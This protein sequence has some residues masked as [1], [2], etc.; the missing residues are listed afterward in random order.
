MGDIVKPLVVLSCGWSWEDC[1]AVFDGAMECFFVVDVNFVE[2][3][4]AT[5]EATDARRLDDVVVTLLACAADK[6]CCDAIKAYEFP[7][8]MLLIVDV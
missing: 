7:L 2:G 3:M 6:F 4:G 8:C 1:V 5:R